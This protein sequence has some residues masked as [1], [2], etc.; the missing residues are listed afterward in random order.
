MA[1]PRTA[2]AKITPLPTPT[3]PPAL[4]KL[5]TM[6]QVEEYLQ[7][8]RDEVRRLVR[9]KGLPVVPLGANRRR[10]RPSALA[11]WLAD[12]ESSGG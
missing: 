9:E 5:L 7:V 10:V 3:P 11:Q 8:G 6:R 2:V 12:Q 1:R 4:E